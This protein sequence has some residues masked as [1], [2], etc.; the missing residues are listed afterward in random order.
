MDL[1]YWPDCR[2]IECGIVFSQRFVNLVFQL[3]PGRLPYCIGPGVAGTV[4]FGTN[5][6]AMMVSTMVWLVT[7]AGAEW[8]KRT[9]AA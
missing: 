9:F 4:A 8:P 3:S 5:G 7:A 2:F 1:T 6:V